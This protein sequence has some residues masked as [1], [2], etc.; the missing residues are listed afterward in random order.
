M[1]ADHIY[2]DISLDL[3]HVELFMQKVVFICNGSWQIALIIFFFFAVA[4][5]ELSASALVTV[6][7]IKIYAGMKYFASC[8]FL[9]WKAGG[10]FL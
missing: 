10:A 2:T 1:Y 8:T 4:H 9:D 6:I 3:L 5:M 7:L